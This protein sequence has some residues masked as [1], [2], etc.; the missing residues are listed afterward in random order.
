MRA[1]LSRFL[2]FS[3]RHQRDRDLADELNTHLDAHIAENVRAGLTFDHARGDALL[4][5]GGLAQA[6]E[7]CRDRRSLPF[8]ETTMQDLRYALRMLRKTQGFAAA[9]ILTLA[10]GIGAN[11]AIFSVV[12]AVLLRPLGYPEP[13]RIVALVESSPPWAP[14]GTWPHINP[15]EFIVEREQKQ[16]FKDIAAYVDGGVVNLTGG[17]QPEQLRDIRVSAAYF[18]VFGAPVAIGRT[19][20]AEE[21]RPGGPRVAVISSGLWHRRFGGARYSRTTA[22]TSAIGDAAAAGELVVRWRVHDR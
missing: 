17:D 8:V 5:L 22:A 4:K 12:N 15:P 20:S 7:A 9:A 6:V 16:V 10:L 19:F 2:G 14:G 3:S 13:D 18:R 11:T 1:W 21:D